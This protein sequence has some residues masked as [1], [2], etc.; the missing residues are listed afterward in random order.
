MQKFIN[1]SWAAAPVEA[2]LGIRS[3]LFRSKSHSQK[4]TVSDSLSSLFKKERPWANISRCCLQQSDDS[5]STFNKEWRDVSD[6]HF[7]SFTLKNK[8]FARKNCCLYC[9]MFLTF[10]TA[11]AI[12][13]FRSQKTSN[14]NEK[15]KNK[16]PT[17][18]WWNSVISE[19]AD[20][21]QQR[22]RRSAGR[23]RPYRWHVGSDQSLPSR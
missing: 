7:C 2:G 10:F 1:L 15:P 20:R 6:S 17:L 23:G 5:E 9:N 16:F 11:F 18:R 12:L 8:W 19:S 14:S 3:S 4:A 21:P 13:L 22:H